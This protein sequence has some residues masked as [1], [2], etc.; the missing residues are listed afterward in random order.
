MS[1]LRLTKCQDIV[2]CL[3][4]PVRYLSYALLVDGTFES[5]I[6]PFSL[7]RRVW[8]LC[9]SEFYI[10]RRIVAPKV[11]SY[12]RQMHPFTKPKFSRSRMVQI[13]T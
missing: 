1:D 2:T 12:A 10:T 6:P 5:Q 3:Q 7:S 13:E 11:E 8:F 4:G 9:L